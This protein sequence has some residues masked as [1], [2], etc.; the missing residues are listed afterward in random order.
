[1]KIDFFNDKLPF[2]VF[3]TM[4]ISLCISPTNQS[5]ASLTE[6]ITNTVKTSDKTPVFCR[7]YADVDAVVKK[8][9]SA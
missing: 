4:F 8:I 7:A 5:F 1:M 9:S 6:N 3:L 2:L